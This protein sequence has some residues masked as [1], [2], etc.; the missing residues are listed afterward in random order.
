MVGQQQVARHAGLLVALVVDRS[1]DV[2]VERPVVTE[3]LVDVEHHVAVETAVVLRLV[4]VTAVRSAK[5][6]NVEA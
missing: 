3:G 4:F 2:G 6:V 1:A 5:V